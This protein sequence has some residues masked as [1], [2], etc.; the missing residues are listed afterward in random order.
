MIYPT[1]LSKAE[2]TLFSATDVANFLACHHVMTLDRAEA[3][4]GQKKP[5]LPD[6]G[7]DLLREMGA[8]HEQDYLEHLLG[9]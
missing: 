7:V 3:A 6:L 8:K 1:A 5:Y 2:A 9:D 4:G